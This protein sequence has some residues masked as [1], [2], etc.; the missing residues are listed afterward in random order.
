MFRGRVAL[1]QLTKDAPG[2][3]CERG[4]SQREG[5]ECRLSSKSK[6]LDRDSRQVSDNHEQEDRTGNGDVRLHFSS[7][8]STVEVAE[9]VRLFGGVSSARDKSVRTRRTLAIGT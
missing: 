9:I 8:R 4:R 1:M 5:N 2:P 3:N 6:A 7:R